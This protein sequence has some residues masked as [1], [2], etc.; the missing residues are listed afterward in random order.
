MNTIKPKILIVDDIKANLVALERVLNDLNVKCVRAS[1]GNEALTQILS[2]E[3]A[4]IIS[5]VQMPIMDGFEL[6]EILRGD[7]KT[8]N[9]PIIFVSATNKDA[10]H[11]F[12]GYEIGA[13]DYLLKPLDPT[14]IKSKVSIF[15]NLYLKQKETETHAQFLE[16]MVIES[17]KNKKELE[18]AN[19]ELSELSSLDGLTNIANRR[20]FDDF[21]QNSWDHAINTKSPI[22][23]IMIDIDYFKLYNDH[24]GHQS[25]DECIKKVAKVLKT[26]GYRSSDLVARYGGEEF[27]IVLG[28]TSMEDAVTVANNIQLK[29]EALR[30]P[31]ELSLCSKWITISIGVTNITPSNNNG[32]KKFIKAADNALYQSKDRGRNTVSSIELDKEAEVN[33]PA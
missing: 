8:S 33:L 14:I 31:H 23:L 11:I 6:A 25:G 24:Y 27:V 20:T 13:V 28:S 7:S 4:M 29:V 26:R 18:I 9:I 1:S 21:V 19:K 2:T 17:Q 10:K 12:K 16:E 15:L 30:I 32:L 22:S 3:F 5:D